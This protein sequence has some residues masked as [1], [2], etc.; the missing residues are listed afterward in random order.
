MPL[1]REFLLTAACCRW[2][3]DE[4]VIAE[5]R[6]LAAGAIDWP[7]FLRIVRRQR[8]AGLAHHAL[9]AAEIAPPPAV[10][11]ALAAQAQQIARQNLQ[12]AAETARLQGAFDAAGIPVIVLKGVALAQLAY[13]SLTLKHSKDIDLPRAARERENVHCECSKPTATRSCSRRA[14]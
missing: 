5:L 3:L 1:P 9:A 12:Q 13:G 10:A 4:A 7:Y 11:Q 14:G 6:T 2:P 8:V